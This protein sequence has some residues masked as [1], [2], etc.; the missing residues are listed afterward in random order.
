LEREFAPLLAS[1]YRVRKEWDTAE[2]TRFAVAPKLREY[3]IS[4]AYISK[5]LHKGMYQWSLQNDVR[6]NLCGGR[7]AIL[8]GSGLGWLPPSSQSGQSQH[9]RQLVQSLWQQSWIGK[10]SAPRTDGREPRF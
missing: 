1:G 5:L 9:F 2:V 4:P 7:K 10:T 3:G 6:Y 8:A